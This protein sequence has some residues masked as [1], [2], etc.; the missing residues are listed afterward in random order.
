MLHG[1]DSQQR[2]RAQQ[3]VAT[4]FQHC[5]SAT[6]ALQHGGYVPREWTKSILNYILGTCE[7]LIL[8]N[9]IT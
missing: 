9:E 1:G 2:F 8:S 5:L 3:S 7:K 4:L 6:F